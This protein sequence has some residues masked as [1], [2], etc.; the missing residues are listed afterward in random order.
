MSIPVRLDEFLVRHAAAE[1]QLQRRSVP[2]QIELWAEIGR[3]IASEVSAEDLIALTQ[4]LKKVRVERVQAEPLD[5]DDLWSEV[6]RARASG[7]L[8][9]GITRQRTVYQASA[10]QPGYLEALYPDGSRA[11]GRFVNGAFEKLD[12]RDNAA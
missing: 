5:S 3:C 9:R 6:E 10:S 2:K 7:E 11:V 8:S 12:G 1:S 4:G